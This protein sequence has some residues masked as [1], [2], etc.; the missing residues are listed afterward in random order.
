MQNKPNIWKKAYKNLS[1]GHDIILMIVVKTSGSAPGKTGFKMLVSET[2]ELYGTIGGGGTEFIMVEKAK[3]MLK[4][5][6]RSA[7]I[8]DFEHREDAGEKSSG[9]ICSG[10]NT[11]AG[12]ALGSDHKETMGRL[13]ENA[14]N[15]IPC[16]LIITS[17]GLEIKKYDKDEG[18]FIFLESED[19]TWRYEENV[20]IRDSLFIIGG[21]H[22]GLALSKISNI[23]GF[24]TIVLD[25]REDLDTMNENRFAHERIIVDYERVAEHIQEGDHSYVVI[26]TA[27]HK[28]DKQVLESLVNKEFK[29]LG[30]IASK[31][32]KAEIYKTLM[33]A[34]IPMVCLERVH[35]PIGLP[36]NSITA[37]EIAIS[38][39]AEMIKVKNSGG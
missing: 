35:S 37:E 36:I 21:G 16:R 20:N 24:H 2:G 10:E 28:A 29:Y 6:D 30:M 11:I 8:R 32:K 15:N 22:V 3:Q 25:D 4:T 23:V 38:I 18:D 34:G 13:S 7:F 33:D 17:N 26:M 9:M 12:I 5:G 14:F 19:G 27:G 39:I 31:Q 1:Q